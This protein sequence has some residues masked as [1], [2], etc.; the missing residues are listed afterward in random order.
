MKQREIKFRTWFKGGRWED[1]YEPQMIYEVQKLYDGSLRGPLG[2]MGSF[3]SLLDEPEAFV[4]MQYTGLKDKNGREI[5]EGD[6]LRYNAKD[7][8]GV[9]H[10]CIDEVRMGEWCQGTM[11]EPFTYSGVHTLG[12]SGLGST[13]YG[14]LTAQRASSSEIIGNVH[15]H[16]ELL[17]P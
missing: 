5:Y 10:E 14:H 12:V 8:K 15:E 16:P 6:I 13:W 9:E 7:Y 17:K 2:G 1:D 11:E 3:G 4:V